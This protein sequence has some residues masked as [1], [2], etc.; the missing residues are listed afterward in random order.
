M[1]KNI[2]AGKPKAR[3]ETKQQMPD[4]KAAEAV[5]LFPVHY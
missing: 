2:N 3:G 5:F 4:D 1:Q